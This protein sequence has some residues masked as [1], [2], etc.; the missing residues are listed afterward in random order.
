M[1]TQEYTS[2]SSFTEHASDSR[3]ASRTE[4]WTLNGAGLSWLDGVTFVEDGSTSGGYSYHFDAS[5]D[6]ECDVLTGDGVALISGSGSMGRIA[7]PSVPSWIG[8]LQSWS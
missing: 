7:S 4:D 6:R 1:S 5:H 8:C 3:S 2:G